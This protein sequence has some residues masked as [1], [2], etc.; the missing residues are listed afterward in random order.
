[1]AATAVVGAEAEVPPG[2]ALAVDA[3]A[4]AVGADFV[5]LAVELREPVVVAD[6]AAVVVVLAAVVDLA[7]VVD[8]A[9]VVDLA[10]EAVA[11]DAVELDLPA[12]ALAE[13]LAFGTAAAAEV[14]MNAGLSAAGTNV[15]ASRTGQRARRPTI[16]DRIPTK[17]GSDWAAEPEMSLDWNGARRAHASKRI[18]DGNN[19]S[20]L[21]TN[22]THAKPAARPKKRRAQSPKAAAIG[23]EQ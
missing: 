17:P 5:E 22:K 16:V 15:N 14:A 7:V 18:D 3:L 12:D 11:F 9:V 2:D 8:F 1:L 19:P 10:P 6:L 21:R 23:A 4:T 20:R 13:L